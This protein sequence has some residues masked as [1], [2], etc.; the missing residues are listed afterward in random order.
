ML[1]R[2]RTVDLEGKD[3]YVSTLIVKKGSGITVESVA[4]CGKRYTFGIGDAQSTSG[5]LAPMTFLFNPRGVVPAECFKTVRSANHQA[6]AFSVASGNPVRAD[7]VIYSLSRAVKLGKSPVFILNELGW[8]ADNVDSFL[9]KVD[10]SHVKVSWPAKVGPSFALSILSAPVAS[11]VDQKEVEAHAKDGD[12][13]N[14]WLHTASAGSGP[15]KIRA[16]QPHE[17]L[18]LDANATSPTGAPKLKGI[19]FKNV[20]DPSARRLLIEQGDADIARDIGADQIA[21]LTGK[22]GINVLSAPSAEVDFLG[23]NAASKTNP[24]TKNPALWEAAR[25]LVDYEGIAKN[26]LKGQSNVHQAFIPKGFAGSLD[27]TPFKLDVE[28]AKG[29]L[30]AAGLDKG[31]TVKLSVINQPPYTDI[32]QALQATFAQAGINL[33][34][35]PA[36][37]SQFYSTLR[38]QGHEA[39]LAFWIPDYFDP[40]SNASAFKPN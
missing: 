36:V 7:D 14:A 19:I 8:S 6:N 24:D 20:A 35:Q 18:V 34:I 40:H 39:A 22:P 33:E 32:A 37:A 21:A 38:S 28:K 1:F 30:K 31:V 10:D 4:Q 11:I 25:W 5:T 13:G 15:F 3:S 12:F 26:L 2:S 9:T 27:D 23:F 16:Y 17:A 29:I